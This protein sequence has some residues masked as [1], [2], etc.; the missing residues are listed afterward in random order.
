[1][2]HTAHSLAMLTLIL[3]LCCVSITRGIAAEATTQPWPSNGEICS[4]GSAGENPAVLHISIGNLASGYAAVLKLCT[5]NGDPVRCLFAGNTGSSTQ[6]LSAS[7]PGGNYIL[8]IGIGANWYGR[9]AAFGA[10]GTYRRF[11]LDDNQ[12]V[13]PL[14][15]GYTY[16]LYI[17]AAPDGSGASGELIPY[18]SF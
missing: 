12:S 14:E 4:S 5:V 11:L 10:E 7:L 16:S 8:K 18:D 2:K 17:D 13:I 9:Q 3:I 6:Q 1:M 15:T